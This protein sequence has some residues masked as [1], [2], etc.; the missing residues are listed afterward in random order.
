[1][2][3]KRRKRKI[4]REKNAGKDSKLELIVYSSFPSLTFWKSQNIIICNQN[5]YKLK[6]SLKFNRDSLVMIN[7]RCFKSNR[8]VHLLPVGGQVISPCCHT[9]PTKKIK[10]KKVKT[11]RD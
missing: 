10:N 3:T 6:A 5:S 4:K 8:C 2:K 1:M 7:Y 11:G 9:P